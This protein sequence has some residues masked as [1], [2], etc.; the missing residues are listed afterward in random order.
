MCTLAIWIRALPDLALVVAANRDELLARPAAPPALLAA[1]PRIVGGRDL[2]AGGTWLGISERGMVAGI[3]NRRT[4][5]PPSAGKRSRGELPLRMLAAPT[6]AAAAGVLRALAPDDYN[7]FNLLVADRD[8][9]WVAQNRDG[10][11]QLQPLDPGLHLCTNLDV[12]DPTCPRIA[13]SHRLFAAVGDDYG[14]HR[15]RHRLRTALASLLA[16]HATALDPRLPDEIESLCVHAGPYGTRCS[17]LLFLDAHGWEHWFAD[18][19]PCRTA[20]VAA[21]T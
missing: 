11:I 1:A 19:A 17:S 6:A 8:H 5:T 16:D 21:P 7:A 13:R 15:D 4:A 18:G 20:Y 12:N 2:E 14:A 10:G 9:A 3:L